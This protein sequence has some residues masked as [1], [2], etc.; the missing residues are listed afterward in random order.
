MENYRVHFCYLDGVNALIGRYRWRYEVMERTEMYHQI[1][2]LSKLG[3]T[4]F[5][6]RRIGTLDE[7]VNVGPN[8]A[9]MLT[10]SA[11][12]EEIKSEFK[13]HSPDY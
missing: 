10:F 13:R 6:Y 9:T 4:D 12:T 7:W 11:H 5:K 1:V 2:S 3:M 8:V